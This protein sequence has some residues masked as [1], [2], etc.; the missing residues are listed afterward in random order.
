MVTGTGNRATGTETNN[1]VTGTGSGGGSAEPEAGDGSAGPGSGNKT[2]FIVFNVV[3]SYFLYC[4]LQKN[5]Q[6]YGCALVV[7]LI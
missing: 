4:N 5:L 7:M 2:T 1:K 6:I 3:M